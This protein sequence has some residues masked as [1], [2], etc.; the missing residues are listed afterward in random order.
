MTDADRAP[1]LTILHE[2]IAEWLGAKRNAILA[3]SA[4]KQAYRE[5]LVMSPEVKLVYLEGGY[6]LFARR[7]RERQGHFAKEAILAGQ[8]RDLEEPNNAVVIDANHFPE[9]IVAEICGQLALP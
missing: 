2:K 5:R 9:E 8:F 6:E 7:I 3:C 4:L 1:W